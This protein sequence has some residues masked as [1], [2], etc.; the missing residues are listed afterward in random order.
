M[1]ESFDE[2][3]LRCID[4]TLGGVLGLLVRDAI[5][6]QLLTK[7]SITREQLPSHLGD[8]VTLLGSAFG[9]KATKTISKA[10]AKRLC[11]ELHIEFV[12]REDFNLEQYVGQVK[13][14]NT[15]KP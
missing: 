5:Y 6:L 2:L 8:F 11:F 7:F 9:P 15:P 10:I 3:L 13:R 14:S 4:E 12:D 1:T